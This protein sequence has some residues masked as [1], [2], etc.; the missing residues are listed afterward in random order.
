MKNGR[1]D[2]SVLDANNGYQEGAFRDGR[3]FVDKRSPIASSMTNEQLQG[4]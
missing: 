3:T 4:K 2:Y 1:E